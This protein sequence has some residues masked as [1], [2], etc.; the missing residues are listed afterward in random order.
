MRAFF[1]DSPSLM[2]IIELAP[3]DILHVSDNVAACAGLAYGL[4]DATRIQQ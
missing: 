1:D 4:A 3:E 2:G